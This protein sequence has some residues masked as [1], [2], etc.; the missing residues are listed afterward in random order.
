MC[1]DW[2]MEDNPRREFPTQNNT[3]WLDQNATEI[4]NRADIL[5]FILFS[6]IDHSTKMISSEQ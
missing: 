3:P 1:Y 4:M 6:L 5:T 2:G